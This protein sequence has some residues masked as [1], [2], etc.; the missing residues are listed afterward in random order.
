MGEIPFFPAIALDKS[1]KHKLGAHGAVAQKDAVAECL[2]K[3]WSHEFFRI[4][5]YK[6]QRSGIVPV[7]GTNDKGTAISEDEKGKQ[8]W[9]GKAR[10]H[11]PVQ[12]RAQKNGMLHN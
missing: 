11:P 2:E 12:R 9:K 6:T 5:G 3:G 7:T 1:G 4:Y 8:F 10:S